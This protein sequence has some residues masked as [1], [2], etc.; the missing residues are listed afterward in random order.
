MNPGT[1]PQHIDWLSA[2]CEEQLT[3]LKRD[4]L[5]NLAREHGLEADFASAC[6]VR[7]ACCEPERIC[8]EPKPLPVMA[9]TCVICWC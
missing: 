3:L 2:A 5:P 1:S 8:I 9:I 7:A 4:F 6:K